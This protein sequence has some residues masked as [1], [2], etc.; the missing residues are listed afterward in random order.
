MQNR[1]EYIVSDAYALLESFA[2]STT[3]KENQQSV[4]IECERDSKPIDCVLLAP[5]WGG[6]EYIHVKNYDLHTMVTSGDFFDLIEKTGKVAKN[7]ICI[8]P[9]NTQKA[10]LDEIC[11]TVLT[12]GIENSTHFIR[13][14]P[15][16]VEDIYVRSKCK[17]TVAY[18]GPMFA[19]NK[20]K[21]RKS[22]GNFE[23]VKTMK[24]EA[25]SS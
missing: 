3:H 23:I 24:S 12:S 19:N 7:I 20:G 4:D 25:A 21:K 10:Q 14:F 15:C 11:S 13:D 2:L 6:S 18:F 5:P 8:L 16:E 22:K 17:M 1:F 9:R